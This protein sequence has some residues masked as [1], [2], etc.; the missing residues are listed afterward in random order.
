VIRPAM[1]EGGPVSRAGNNSTA[2]AVIESCAEKMLSEIRVA[3]SRVKFRF[4]QEAHST[5]NPES[6]GSHAATNGLF[7]VWQRIGESAGRRSTSS[8][9]RMD[10]EGFDL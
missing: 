10:D 2:K 7:I 9:N 3:R 8:K 5:R 6:S 1:A 4:R